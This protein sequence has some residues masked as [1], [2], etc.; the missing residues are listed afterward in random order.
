MPTLCTGKPASSWMGRPRSSQRW[1]ARVTLR[2]RESEKGGRDFAEGPSQGGR[3]LCGLSVSLEGLTCRGIK[4]QRRRMEGGRPCS[5]PARN[6]R[7][8]AGSQADNRFHRRID[9]GR[10]CPGDHE[11]DRGPRALLGLARLASLDHTQLVTSEDESGGGSISALVWILVVETSGA[12]GTQPSRA[13][14][15]DKSR[16]QP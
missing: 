5:P 12:L 7:A 14:T 4:E 6:P 1:L 16:R 9:Q 11:T 13:R 10:L 15:G 8:E 2:N 3:D